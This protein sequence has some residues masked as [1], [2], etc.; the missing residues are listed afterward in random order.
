MPSLICLNDQGK[1]I[2]LKK[3]KL[4]EMATVI[5]NLPNDCIQWQVILKKRKFA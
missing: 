5:L 3:R 4:A 1:W 2:I